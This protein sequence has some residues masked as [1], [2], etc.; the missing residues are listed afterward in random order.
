[1]S[2]D[3]LLRIK[4]RPSHPTDWDVFLSGEIEP[5][6]W[7]EWIPDPKVPGYALAAR[8]EALTKYEVDIIYRHMRSLEFSGKLVN[9]VEVVFDRE[10]LKKRVDSLKE[11]DCE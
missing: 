7:Y 1:M 11:L 4:R 6:G 2:N 8:A 10:R 3:K 9:M 5:Q